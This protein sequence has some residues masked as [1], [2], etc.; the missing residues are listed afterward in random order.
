M[1]HLVPGLLWQPEGFAYFEIAEECEHCWRL[2]V[3]KQEEDFARFEIVE[4]CGFGHVKSPG[5]VIVLKVVVEEN[6]V[7]DGN[8]VGGNL[9]EVVA[10]R[11]KM[12]FPSL[13]S[14]KRMVLNKFQN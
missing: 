9:V 13:H 2:V 11:L 8:A 7:D 14:F 12:I 4:D 6:V 1:K 10:N 5:V 3:E